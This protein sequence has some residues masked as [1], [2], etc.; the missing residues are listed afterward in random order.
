[1]TILR[2]HQFL[3]Y[4]LK[5]KAY[6]AGPRLFT[7]IDSSIMYDR[8]KTNMIDFLVAE[9]EKQQTAFNNTVNSTIQSYVLEMKE[10]EYN[11]HRKNA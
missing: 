10:G 5:K 8:V 2:K 11:E 6:I 4:S 3:Q 9:H 7:A 1:M